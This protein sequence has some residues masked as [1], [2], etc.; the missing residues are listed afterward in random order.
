MLQNKFLVSFH[1]SL[2]ITCF[3]LHTCIVAEKKT[4]YIM[5]KSAN[6]VI[7]IQSINTYE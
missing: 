4:C 3:P 5:K 6:K 7:N 1:S 2:I